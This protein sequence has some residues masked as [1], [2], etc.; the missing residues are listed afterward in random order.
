MS[1]KHFG[2]EPKHLKTYF[3]HTLL[4]YIDCLSL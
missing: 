1:V 4:K 3:S 2:L